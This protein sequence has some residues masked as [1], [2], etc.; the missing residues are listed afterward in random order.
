[1]GNKYTKIQAQTHMLDDKKVT[2]ICITNGKYNIFSKLVLQ[3][4]QEFLKTLQNGNS[5]DYVVF[6]SGRLVEEDITENFAQCTGNFSTG[7]HVG[8]MA[9]INTKD[10][11]FRYSEMGQTVMKTIRALQQK[12]IV[13]LGD[14]WCLG[15][16]LELSLSCDLLIAHPKSRFQLPE[17][18]M[19]I[20]PGWGGTQTLPYRVGPQKAEQWLQK[21]PPQ[22]LSA[23]D[24]LEM[25][26]IDAIQENPL[27]FVNKSIR[28][29]TLPPSRS[30]KS[31]NPLELNGTTIPSYEAEAEIFSEFFTTGVPELLLQKLKIL[32][33]K[34]T[35]KAL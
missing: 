35:P 31:N 21:N 4:L 15:G 2:Y 24:A 18:P 29:D 30:L 34:N 13:A 27:G 17:I 33:E 23:P 20:I 1:M 9:E 25:C 8:E 10:E 14:G 7:A 19:G 6:H 32:Q 11:A 12:T 22:T 5:S 26:L 28:S 16:G 3:E